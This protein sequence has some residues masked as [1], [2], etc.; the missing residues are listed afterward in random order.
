MKKLL[1][2]MAVSLLAACGSLQTQ[3]PPTPLEANARSGFDTFAAGTLAPIGSFEWQAAP[4]YTQNAVLRHNAARALQ[5]GS[6][7]LETAEEIQKRTDRVRELLDAAVKAD[8]LKMK[9]AV[10]LLE[11]AKQKLGAAQALLGAN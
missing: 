1:L 10:L 5:K 6:I 4:T 2:V 3:Q 7:T 11:S 9:E 8:A